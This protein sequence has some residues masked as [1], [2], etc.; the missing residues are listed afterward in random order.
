MVGEKLTLHTAI[1]AQR[2]V[3]LRYA[4]AD[5]EAEVCF[6]VRFDSAF[7]HRGCH[8][9]RICRKRGERTKLRRRKRKGTRLAQTVKD[10]R[11]LRP[12]AD[13]PCRQC[14]SD[15]TRMGCSA[16]SRR[17]AGATPHT[18]RSS[19]SFLDASAPVCRTHC[20]YSYYLFK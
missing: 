18:P 2:R 14:S 7:D 19:P 17:Y 5:V 10:D 6:L 16:P 8:R 3:V 20:T 11:L 9:A 1:T 12:T 4:I 15:P 13:V